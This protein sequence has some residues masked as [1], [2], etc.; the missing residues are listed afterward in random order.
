VSSEANHLRLIVGEP[1][2]AVAVGSSPALDDTE[3]LAA[4]RAG[5]PS[6]ATALHDRTHLVVERTIKRLLGPRDRESE[7]L[8]QLAFI[9]LVDTIEQFRGDCPLNA[10]VSVIAARVVYKDLRRR[11]LERRFFSGTPLQLVPDV[12]SAPRQ[13]SLLRDLLHR[14]SDHLKRVDESRALTFLLHDAY[15]YDL[16]EIAQIT[17]VSVAAA[18][19]RLVR[20]RREV[21]ER[22]ANDPGLARALDDWR[23]PGDP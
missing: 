1:R 22:I 18:Q 23:D 12:I 8:C 2:A 9:E 5:D 21:H 14:V 20:G 19:S 11:K 15:G 6:A 3:L 10:W 16:K 13:S 4:L 17:G 7:D